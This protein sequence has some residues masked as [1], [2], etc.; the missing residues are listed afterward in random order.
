[1][2]AAIVDSITSEATGFPKEQL[3]DNNPDTYWKPTGTGQQ[4][5]VIDLGSALQVDAFVAFVKDYTTMTGAY[6]Y[7]YRSSDN[8]NWTNIGGSWAIG[9]LTAGPLRFNDLG[10]PLT[11][12]YWKFEILAQSEA[13]Q[14]AG[15]WLCRKYTVA[16][17]NEWPEQDREIYHNRIIEGEGGRDFVIGINRGRSMII[18]RSYKISGATQFGYLRS[19]WRDS[20]GQ[21]RPVIIQEGDT[22][23]DGYLARFAEDEFVKNERAYLYYEP[24]VRF[25][26]M[27]YIDAGQSY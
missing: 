19:A 5:I 1:M 22:Y 26:T 9:D 3:L 11:Y 23:D 27:P 15:L 12:R 4:D 21:L 16:V 10:S 25:N 24:I 20:A 2:S 8:V 14:L 7:R 13:I 17:G 18:P 6:M